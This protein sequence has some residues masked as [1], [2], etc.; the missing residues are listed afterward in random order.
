MRGH[1]SIQG[2]TDVPTLYDLLPGYLPQPAADPGHDD[3]RRLHRARGAADRL[4]GQLPQVHR[5]PAQGVVRRGRAAAND[6]RF[7]W[8]PRIDGDYSQLLTFDRM[9]RGEM[10][11]YFVFGQNPAGGGPNAGLHRAGLRKLDWLVVLDWFETETADLLEER[12]G[13]RRRPREIKTEVFLIPAAVERREGG[14][15]HQ[16]PAPAPVAQQGARPAG[17]LP[18]RRL[19]RLQPR[20]AAARLYAGSTD[21]K[22]Q[23]LLNLTWDYDH[24]E[25]QRLPDGSISR[26]EGEPD[27][28][29]VLAGDQRLP[30]RRGRPAHRTAAAASGASP[31]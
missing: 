26:I 14:H 17:R 22:D 1:S 10:T 18:L 6:F 2:S 13:R 7:D 30:A 15:A 31:S 9:S 21:P 19:V 28:E 8:L 3:A 12:P 16:H 24:D 4:L 20:Q 11:G 27:V 25:P 23:P 29:K 5:Q